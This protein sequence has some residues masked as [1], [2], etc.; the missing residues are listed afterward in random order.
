M[1]LEPG[2]EGLERQRDVLALICRGL[3][4]K[5]IADVLGI[6]LGTVKVHCSAIFEAL[7]V[8]NRTEAV[9]VSRQLGIAVSDEDG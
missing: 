6:G 7:E 9:L 8:T 5:E 2:E 3:T 4:N 1:D